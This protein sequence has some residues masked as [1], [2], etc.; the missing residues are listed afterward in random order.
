MTST[1][2]SGVTARKR[3]R[4]A[5]SFAFLLVGAFALTACG[6]GAGGQ[7]AVEDLQEELPDEIPDGT[8]LRIGDQQEQQ[9][10]LFEASGEL[11]EFEFDDEF[12]NFVGGPAILEAFRA[13][14]LDVARVGDTPPIHAHASGE[15]VP[16]ILAFRTD[17]NVSRL[18]TSPSTDIDSIDDLEGARIAYAEG[19]AQASTVLRLLDRAE[20]ETDDVELVPLQLAEYSEALQ[21]DEVDIAPLN[22]AR[23]ARYLEEYDGDGAGYL[24]EEETS[25]LGTGLSFIYA[26]QE[27]LEDPAKAAA[28]K[29][30]V[31]HSIRATHWRN[32]NQDI[33]VQEY[34][35]DNQGITEEEGYQ[36]VEEEGITV[37]PLLED[38]IDE[39]QAT[40]D[41]AWDAGELPVEVDADDMFDL[42]FDEVIEE[43]VAEL[44]AHHDREELDE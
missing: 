38:L 35:V 3:G 22:G 8:L 42:R 21:V 7:I 5:R 12:N 1:T 14:A 17:P 6:G 25:G 16:I 44:D 20:L 11:D 39:Q 26:R 9:Q 19:T 34:F 18:A 30:Y 33:W 36:F 10:V 24:P 27:V 41:L 40:I 32:E 4:A 15:D 23:L 43:T 31:E 29:A 28:L 13:E 2:P 37:F